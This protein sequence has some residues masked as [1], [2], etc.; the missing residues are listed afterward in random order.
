MKKLFIILVCLILVLC[1]TGCT[2][3]KNYTYEEHY[4]R[5]EKLLKERYINESTEYTGYQLF[6]LYNEDD[7]FCLFLI[8]LEPYGFVYVEIGKRSVPFV[9][10]MYFRCEGKEWSRYVYNDVDSKYIDDRIVYEVDE[11]GEKIV[12]NVSPFKA[13]NVLN[14]KKYVLNVEIEGCARILVAV[15]RGDK[16]LNL[17]SMK[18]FD[19]VYKMDS[20]EQPFH[21]IGFVKKKYFNL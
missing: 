1:L 17:I 11:N 15:K 3:S 20:Y 7:E 21:S 16:Y 12:Y 4:K 13:A 10:S 8:E 18:E 19:Y 6:P 9:Y 14:E 2:Y 5:V